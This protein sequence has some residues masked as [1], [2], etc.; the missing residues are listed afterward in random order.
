MQGEKRGSLAF[1]R[2][3]E[4]TNVNFEKK[5]GLEFSGVMPDITSEL[6]YGTD[7]I[8]M[9]SIMWVYCI[10]LIYMVHVNSEKHFP[11]HVWRNTL[12]KMLF[13]LLGQHNTNWVGNGW[14]RPER[15]QLQLQEIHVFVHIILNCN[16]VEPFEMI[17][18]Y[19]LDINV[20]NNFLKCVCLES[21]WLPAGKMYAG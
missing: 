1:L 21:Q 8:P 4:G 3:S 15:Q 9:T 16:L 13:S 6:D 17:F 12:E 18:L 5:I 10:F 19:Q 20:G 7:N 2:N 11:P 14:H